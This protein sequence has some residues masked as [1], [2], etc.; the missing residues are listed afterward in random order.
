MN[1]LVNEVETRGT[2]QYARTCSGEPGNKRAMLLVEQ[3]H[4]PFCTNE[5]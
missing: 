4:L 5:F 1:Q 3:Q 2:E